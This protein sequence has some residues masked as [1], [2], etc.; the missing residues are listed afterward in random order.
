[1]IREIMIEE[2]EEYFGGDYARLTLPAWFWFV[3][4]DANIS[5]DEIAYLLVTQDN[6]SATNLLVFTVDQLR[7]ASQEQINAYAKARDAWTEM[8]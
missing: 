7:N 3:F 1:M 4:S 6:L 5:V 8:P 2:V